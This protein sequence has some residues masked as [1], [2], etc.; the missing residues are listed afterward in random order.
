MCTI[1]TTRRARTVGAINQDKVMIN[2][3]VGAAAPHRCYCLSY[4]YLQITS[5]PEHLGV[6]ATRKSYA[7]RVVVTCTGVGE[8]S[9]GNSKLM[10]HFL[11]RRNLEFHRTSVPFAYSMIPVWAFSGTPLKANPLDFSN[12]IFNRF[13]SSYSIRQIKIDLAICWMFFFLFF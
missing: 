13:V 10:H 3:L 11:S 6:T 4:I 7:R 12:D 9:R 2:K 5:R 1:G 8:Y